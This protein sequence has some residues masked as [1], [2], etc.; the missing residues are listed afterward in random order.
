MVDDCG[1]VGSRGI[2]GMGKKYASCQSSGVLDG[3]TQEDC[4]MLSTRP[5]AGAWLWEATDPASGGGQ[6]AV[7]GTRF[8]A[9]SIPDTAGHCGRVE[10][11]MSTPGRLS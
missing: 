3:Q 4:H 5:R 2:K 8:S 9:A 6:G 1:A 11:R 10:N 7:L